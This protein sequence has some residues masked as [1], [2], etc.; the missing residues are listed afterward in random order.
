MK[1]APNGGQSGR[2]VLGVPEWKRGASGLNVDVD[3][4]LPGVGRR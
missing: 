4:D 2:Y 3:V 1:A